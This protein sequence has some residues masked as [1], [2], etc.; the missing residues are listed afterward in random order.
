MKDLFEYSSYKTYLVDWL[1]SPNGGGGHGSRA[2][3]AAA[4]PCQLPYVAQVLNGSAQFSSE[5][6]EAINL[7]LGHS[8]DQSDFFLILV[9]LERAGTL[10]LKRRIQAQLARAKKAQLVQRERPGKL[11]PL[12]ETDKTSYYD[13]WYTVAIHVLTSVPQFQTATSIAE[14][15][16]LDIGKVREALRFLTSRKFVK[17]VGER[18]VVGTQGIVHIAG[19]NE[20]LRAKHHANWRLQ[21]IR[22]LDRTRAQ[23]GHTELHYTA[24][25]SISQ[26]DSAKVRKAFADAIAILGSLVEASAEEEV[27]CV[28]LDFFKV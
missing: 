20:Q 18:Y 4:I 21:A 17:R 26:A 14:H 13:A 2:K 3:L 7:Y 25:V 11:R 10:A 19:E 23:S 9:Q 12:S 16:R 1:K 6:A 27:R 15:L 22:S 24:V 8:D 28:S 5:Q